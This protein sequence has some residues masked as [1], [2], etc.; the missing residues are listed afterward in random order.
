MCSYG[1]VGL[2]CICG[3]K[4]RCSARLQECR[5]KKHFCLVSLQS[6]CG[7]KHQCS[8]RLQECCGKKHFCLVSLQSVCGKK[9]Q[10]SARLQECYGKK[11]FCL[12]SLQSI[13]GRKHRYSAR[14]QKC[15]GKKHF[16]L[17]DLQYHSF[18]RPDFPL[19]PQF[20]PFRSRS[21][22]C[23][24][25]YFRS[26]YCFSRINRVYTIKICSTLLYASPS[27][28]NCLSP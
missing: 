2:Q 1:F 11:H 16:C 9:H 15:C 18:Q 20:V 8:A 3:K 24:K 17:V 5:G 26:L 12:V 4:H 23:R 13:C 14:L 28:R 22:T 25:S 6:V 10:C 27:G 21:L 19:Q 7:K